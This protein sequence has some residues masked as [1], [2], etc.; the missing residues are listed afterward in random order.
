MGLPNE[1]TS[2]KWLAALGLL[3]AATAF[4]AP[5]SAQHYGAQGHVGR[6]KFFNPG[7]S[8]RPAGTP[9]STVPEFAE[10]LGAG[11]TPDHRVMV[12]VR[13]PVRPW[14]GSP[15]IGPDHFRGRGIFA[16]VLRPDA[17]QSNA[18]VPDLTNAWSPS[19]MV[20]PSSFDQATWDAFRQEPFSYAAS[21]MPPVSAQ[22]LFHLSWVQ[23]NPYP[24]T[25]VP[26]ESDGAGNPLFQAGAPSHVTY[27]LMLSATSE[28][29][30]DPTQF[31]ALDVP[32][33]RIRALPYLLDPDHR[34]ILGAGGLP[35]VDP[36][37]VLLRIVVFQAVRIVVADPD[38]AN[39]RVS[40]VVVDGDAVYPYSMEPPLYGGPAPSTVPQNLIGIEPTMTS[41]GR[42]L[43]F[44][45][46][47]PEPTPAPGIPT[48]PTENQQINVYAQ[49]P[50]VTVPMP[51]ASGTLSP[52]GPE[53]VSPQPW[54]AVFDLRDTALD[55][56]NPN[57]PSWQDVLP[58]ARQPIRTSDGQPIPVR[59]FMDGNYPWLAN[60]P[61][62][63]LMTFN[64]L[65]RHGP[66]VISEANNF[67][68]QPVDGAGESEFF[69]G[70]R[71]GGSSLGSHATWPFPFGSHTKVLPYT[72]HP[73][74][75]LAINLWQGDAFEVP[76]DH[77][78]DYVFKF[79]SL[80]ALEYDP[81]IGDFTRD[82]SKI[83]DVS[84]NGNS[85]IP[86]DAFSVQQYRAHLGLCADT[87]ECDRQFGVD[88]FYGQ[89]LI[90]PDVSPINYVRGSVRIDDDP[91]FDRLSSFTFQAQ[92]ALETPLNT[93]PDLRPLFVRAGTAGLL[94]YS[95]AD[96]L[97]GLIWRDS[98]LYV[99]ITPPGV[100]PAA[101]WPTGVPH[102][103]DYHH[104]ALTYDSDS[105]RARI[106]VDGVSVHE[107]LLPPG[108][109]DDLGWPAFL[110]P[111]AAPWIFSP[112]VAST[113]MDEIS[114]AVAALDAPA[115]KDAAF[116]A[117]HLQT[118][119]EPPDNWWTVDENLPVPLGQ[120]ASLAKIPTANPLTRAKAL[121]GR[122][123][124]KETSFSSPPGISCASCHQPTAAFADTRAQSIGVGGRTSRNA[125]TIAGTVYERMLLWDGRGGTLEEQV[126]RAIENPIEMNS[127]MPFIVGRLNG[128]LT[129]RYGPLFNAAFGTSVV[130][131]TMVRQAF[132]SYQRTIVPNAS[133]VDLF[134]AGD[135]SQ[136]TPP[137]RRGRILFRGKAGCASCHV[138]PTYS[139]GRIHRSPIL[140]TDLGRGGV[141][142]L[143]SQNHAFKTPSLRNVALT[144]PY[145]H[146]GSVETL[147]EV[148]DLYDRGTD[149]DHPELMRL[150]LTP[151]EK[152][153]LVEFLRALTGTPT[154]TTEI[155]AR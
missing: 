107:R 54:N 118:F 95:I 144:P 25:E 66:A 38:T 88:G 124:F 110:G 1:T 100:L 149:F 13:K 111:G 29:Y 26:Y 5:T 17:I 53:F 138:P 96:A 78:A 4:A 150:F 24:D 154:P 67:T 120:D 37:L 146:D 64:A 14:G 55:P 136:L 123:L 93:T 63:L 28:M 27:K 11:F 31:N 7:G 74:S 104:V 44:I 82:H 114:L 39:A 6:T 21:A 155:D 131:E 142:K 105:G 9:E 75:V 48:I 151:T 145:F 126:S 23:A 91:T 51:D 52:F 41:H 116:D 57:A 2:T 77:A 103:S 10:A 32:G 94:A 140:T 81:G 62:K 49:H 133:R 59:F 130:T 71:P 72:N 125:P 113:A 69:Y 18:G 76:V 22:G 85:G 87:Y 68:V 58:Y 35:V 50:R 132:A 152:T 34:F 16:T 84:G 129:G 143:P 45:D 65:H 47:D 97:I 73:E 15:L 60:L 106:L 137:E 139:N 127:S 102:A 40:A 112:A 56:G 134:E 46:D 119:R 141:T 108:P 33:S 153:D 43:T 122:Q 135:P 86:A 20:L 90:M 30:A 128:P 36:T 42:V 3:A 115:Y 83:A 92:V 109:V 89:T 117:A 99:L 148:V 147:E 80:P 19:V 98:R 101:D 79:N 70:I 121:L 8:L 61:G 12:S